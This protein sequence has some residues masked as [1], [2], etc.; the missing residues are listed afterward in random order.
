MQED[1]KPPA[2]F[3]RQ[4]QPH[5]LVRRTIALVLAGGRGSRLKQLTDRRAKPA[6]YFGGKFRI[7]DFSLSNCVNSDID[8]V[9][10]LT[11][12]NPRSLNDHIGLGRP[13]DLDRNHGGVKLLHQRRHLSRTRVVV[14]RRPVRN[15]VRLGLH[16]VYCT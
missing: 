2:P 11:Q 9:V 6:V 15:E 8:D 14:G 3:D 7:I 5:M 4:M 13:W 16:T 10:V 12:Y 1:N